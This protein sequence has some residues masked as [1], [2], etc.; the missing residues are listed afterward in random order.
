MSAI[1]LTAGTAFALGAAFALTKFC[2]SSKPPAMS[3]EEFWH[4]VS[5]VESATVKKGPIIVDGKQYFR[6]LKDAQ[7]AF[8]TNCNRRSQFIVDHAYP[9]V[10]AGSN[11]LDLGSG[12][13]ANSAPLCIYRCNVTAID[14]MVETTVGYQ[15]E[16][17]R[18]T[19]KWH[20]KHQN[21]C[22][23]PTTP[24]FI[25]GDIASCKYPEDVDLVICEDTLPYIKPVNLQT[26]LAKIFN[27][28]RPG[29]FF[30]GSI[31]FEPLT[32]DPDLDL[33]RKIGAHFYPTKEMALEIISRSGFEIRQSQEI[34][35]TLGHPNNSVHFLAVKP[36]KPTVYL[37]V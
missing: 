10:Q 27:A 5:K 37:V 6:S 7:R 22:N 8:F 3:N 1:Y 13:G 26:T 17:S 34:E 16:L 18:L 25:V 36:K 23:P 14:K 33:M 21:E 11:V 29:G 15:K 9:L 20:E 31:F 28:I 24:T 30:V 35:N 12:T 2:K 4:T 19:T 32:K